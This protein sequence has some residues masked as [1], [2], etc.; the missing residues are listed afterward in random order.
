MTP[1]YEEHDPDPALSAHVQ[2]LWR[3]EGDEDGVE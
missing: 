2:C 3:F 1:R